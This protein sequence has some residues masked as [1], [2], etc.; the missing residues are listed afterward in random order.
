MDHHELAFRQHHAG[1][2]S[3]CRRDALH[4]IEKPV[5]TGRNVGA[6]LNVV[7][8]PEPFGGGIVPPIE[9]RLERLATIALFLA[10]MV[11]VIARKGRVQLPG[12]S[13]IA[14]TRSG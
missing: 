2:V 6:V 13:S 9:Q 1:L 11:C 8:R 3:Q 12:R 7:G 14:S 4:Q 5:A 10:S